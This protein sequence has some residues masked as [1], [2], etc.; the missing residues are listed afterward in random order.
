MPSKSPGIFPAESKLLAD[1]GERLKLARLRRKLST[2]TVAAR[3]SISRPTLVKA[4]TGDSSVTLGTYLRILKVYGLEAGLDAL[5][6]DDKL[7]R[8]LQDLDIKTPR[9]GSR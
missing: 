4:E 6:A 5:A 7:G 3:S 1:F 8:R 2:M 9:K